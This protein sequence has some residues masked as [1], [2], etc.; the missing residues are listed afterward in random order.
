MVYVHGMIKI[1]C[2]LA[3]NG[4]RSGY[5]FFG[6]LVANGDDACGQ[7]SPSDA[8]LMACSEGEMAQISSS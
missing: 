5:I 3:S 6:G 2:R 1:N 7:S 4:Q 8:V